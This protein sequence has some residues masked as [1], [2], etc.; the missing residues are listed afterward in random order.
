MKPDEE[1]TDADAATKLQRIVAIHEQEGVT[2]SPKAQELALAVL[3]GE[4]DAE[5]AIAQIKNSI[6]P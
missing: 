3:K 6:E 2:P 1:M 5:E 4:I